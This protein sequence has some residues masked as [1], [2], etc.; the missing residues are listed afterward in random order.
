ML[1]DGHAFRN[2]E[3]MR[4]RHVLRPI[5]CEDA[6]GARP[7]DGAGRRLGHPGDDADKG[8]FAR[9]VAAYQPDALGADR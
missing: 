8:G 6:N 3:G 1:E 4:E 5:L 2:A 9:T 7:P